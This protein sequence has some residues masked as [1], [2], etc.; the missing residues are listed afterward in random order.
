MVLAQAS[1]LFDAAGPTAPARGSASGRH[2]NNRRRLG[3]SVVPFAPYGPVNEIS[4]IAGALRG[5]RLSLKCDCRGCLAVSA[6]DEPSLTNVTAISCGPA[7]TVTR[8]LKSLS[9]T[10]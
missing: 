10:V 5:W 6:S 2:T 1:S 4:L 9:S 7:R 8:V 3:V